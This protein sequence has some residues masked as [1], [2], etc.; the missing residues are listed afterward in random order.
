MIVLSGLL[1]AVALVLLV[2]AGVRES[3]DYVYAAIAAIGLG[4]VV[5]AVVVYQRRDELTADQGAEL[6]SEDEG[7]LVS[8]PASAGENAGESAGLAR[9]LQVR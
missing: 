1:T 7:A 4:A 6:R 5:F 3:W 2:L 8:V 9:V